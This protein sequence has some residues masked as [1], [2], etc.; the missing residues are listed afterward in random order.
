EQTAGQATLQLKQGKT[1]GQTFVARYAG[2]TAIEILLTPGQTPD[3][4]YFH[5]QTEP[6]AAGEIA[7]GRV[8]LN[9]QDTPTYVR[10]P[11]P[12]QDSNQAYYYFWLETD[13]PDPIHIAHDR[14]R[15]Y[16]HG[17]A[18]RNHEPVTAQLA[19]R[20]VY[21]PVWV[22]RGLLGEGAVW[23]GMV[24]RPG[25]LFTLPG[26]AL[27]RALYPGW[28][29]RGWEEKLALAGGV[30]LAL[31]PILLAWTD[32]VGLRM[33]A[34]YAWG[35]PILA[36]GYLIWAHRAIPARFGLP[37]P[38][39]NRG[40]GNPLRAGLIQLM[41]L[42]RRPQTLILLL[43][44]M[45]LF[46]T[47]F[48]AIRSLETGMW[49]DSYQHTLI[50]QLLVDHGGLFDS[51]Q[52]YID[53][54]SFTY[55]FGF[56]TS[57]AL[58]HWLTGMGAAKSVLWAGQIINVLA[59]FALLPLTNKVGGNRWAGV[60]AVLLA[61][62][63]INMPSFYV[64]WG[65][66]TQLTGQAILPVTVFLAWDLF[67]REGRLHGFRVL[68]GLVFAGLAMTHYRVIIMA[69]CFFPAYAL[70]NVRQ[71]SWRRVFG[72]ALGFG[73]TAG[74]LFAPWFI[75]VFAGK[76]VDFLSATLSSSAGISQT[77]KNLNRIDDLTRYLP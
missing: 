22:A 63:L 28:A 3:D 34:A 18:Y 41:L 54:T 68:T 45:L 62:L 21:D 17:A 73:V 74:V 27:L 64:N 47:R 46:A 53:L 36:A 42:I 24:L 40:F 49:G 55:H 44:L 31:Y 61:G 32:V 75:N 16:L 51:W 66:Y 48:W 6:G 23:L 38:G 33:G 77:L 4:M 72:H 15:T 70:L 43:I 71:T 59:V 19:F 2:L 60:G 14:A 13:S 20:L 8:P 1:V 9:G 37:N 10:F 12:P 76:L 65:R 39:R 11:F 29:S 26:W 25:V 50:A 56:H 30:S 52:P 57:A 35:P 67:A 69:G 58:L 7:S 5:L